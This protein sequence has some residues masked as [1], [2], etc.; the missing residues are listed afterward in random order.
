MSKLTIEIREN[1]IE[2]YKSNMS[3]RQIANQLGIS[4][5][6]V[7]HLIEKLLKQNS[8]EYLSKGGKPKKYTE[9]NK[10]NLIRI[11]KGNPKSTTKAILYYVIIQVFTKLV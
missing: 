8:L 6:G 3:Q 5:G 4:K 2:L 7:Q 11:S 10:K 1:I 9:R